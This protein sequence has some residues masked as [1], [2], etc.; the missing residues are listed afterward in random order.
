MH[1]SLNET[2]V[3][4][5]TE[6]IPLFE[7]FL[8]ALSLHVVALPVLWMIGWALPWPK[9]PVITTIIEWDLQTWPP[10]AKKVFDFRDPKLNK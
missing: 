3:H 1:K 5:I 7:A 6:T 10:K 2:V 4:F 9:P 8:V